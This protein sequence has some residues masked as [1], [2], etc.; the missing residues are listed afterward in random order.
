MTN[1]VAFGQDPK[2]FYT[3]NLVSESTDGVSWTKLPVPT[4]VHNRLRSA[5]TNGVSVVAVGEGVA[6]SSVD[7]N[8]G[9]TSYNIFAGWV[10]LQKIIHNGTQYYAVG[11][12]KQWDTL[13]EQA[14]VFVSDDGEDSSVWIQQYQDPNSY[15]GLTDIVSLG[16]SNL[17]A[18]GY[19]N[20]MKDPLMLFSSNNGISWQSIVVNPVLQGPLFSVSYNSITNRIW[21]GGQGWIATAIWSGVATNYVVSNNLLNNGKARSITAIANRGNEAVAVGANTVWYSTNNTDWNSFRQDGYT[22]VSA[23]NYQSKWYLGTTSTMNRYTAFVLTGISGTAS[24]SG[25]DCL[26]QPTAWFEV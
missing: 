1:L 3:Q 11:Y 26:V 23:Y 9:W 24:L 14:T 18:V 22:F 7:I 5:A 20:G 6:A 17:L 15:S 8:S 4:A 10:N 12:H 2:A 13:V 21:I 16:G 19:Q 25:L